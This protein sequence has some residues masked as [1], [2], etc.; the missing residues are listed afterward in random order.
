MKLGTT[1]KSAF[2]GIVRTRSR[3]D[4]KSSQW[5]DMDMGTENPRLFQLGIRMSM[6]MY[7]SVPSLSSYLP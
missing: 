6:G 3:F 1:K 2:V 5:L 7:I 4:G